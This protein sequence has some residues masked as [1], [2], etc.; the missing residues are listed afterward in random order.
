M[1]NKQDYSDVT[2]VIHGSKLYAHR[3]VICVQSHYFAK[4][5][6][7]KTFLEGHTGEIRFDDGSALA[8]WRVFE[9]LYTGN[10]TDNLKIEGLQGRNLCAAYA[11]EC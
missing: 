7:E 5:F 10:Y 2:I 6:N 11:F 8:H 3:F 9:Y 4:A 1:F